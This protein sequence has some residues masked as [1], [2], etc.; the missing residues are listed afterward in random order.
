MLAGVAAGLPIPDE[1]WIPSNN[2]V[3]TVHLADNDPASVDSWAAFLGLETP[4]YGSTMRGPRRPFRSYE[5]KGRN[6]PGMPGW[7]VDVQSFCDV[8]ELEAQQAGGVQ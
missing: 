3:F 4:A 2:T 5:A 1:T 6:C 8:A 7:L